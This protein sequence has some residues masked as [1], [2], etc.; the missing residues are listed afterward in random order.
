MPQTIISVFRLP[1][2]LLFYTAIVKSQSQ[3]VVR[4]GMDGTN[5]KLLFTLKVNS[6]MDNVHYLRPLLTIDRISHYLYFYNGF[7]RIF[8]LNMQGEVLHV[9]YQTVHRFHAFKIFAGETTLDWPR[10]ISICECLDKMYKAFGGSNGSEF[11]INAKHALGTTLLGPGFVFDLS[12][13]VQNFYS[14]TSCL[15]VRS[16]RRI[17]LLDRSS[18]YGLGAWALHSMH[19]LYHLRYSMQVIDFVVID[20]DDERKSKS[21]PA[22]AARTCCER[23]HASRE[24]ANGTP[25]G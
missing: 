14:R 21:T 2:R 1:D 15:N 22:G 18:R 3:H 13:M 17:E 24:R 6:D 4:L 11:R 10:I 12:R 20:A 5:L 8:T 9:Q 19:N 23:I 16:P 7:D 25:R